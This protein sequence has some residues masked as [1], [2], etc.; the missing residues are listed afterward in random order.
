MARTRSRSSGLAV[1]SPE[2][3][4]PTRVLKRSS[5]PSGPD[6]VPHFL[7]ELLQGAVKPRRACSRAD[8]EQPCGRFPVEVEQ[9]AQRDHLALGRREAVERRL[10]RGRI[11]VA[12]HLPPDRFRVEQRIGP[13]A[14]PAA[15]LCPEVVESRRAR[16]REEPRLR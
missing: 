14:L 3:S 15:L 6:I 5:N 12:E 7:L 2:R 13:L 4:S 9:D 8:P 11:A 16:E 1:T 10:E